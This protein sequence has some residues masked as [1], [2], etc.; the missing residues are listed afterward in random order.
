[1]DLKT[2]IELDTHDVVLAELGVAAIYRPA[3]DQQGAGYATRVIVRGEPERAAKL[4]A[5]RFA[6]NLATHERRRYRVQ[7][8]RVHAGETVSD[9]KAGDRGGIVELSPGDTLEIAASELGAAGAAG[10]HRLKIAGEAYRPSSVAGWW[11]A[12]GTL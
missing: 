6:S 2:A 4:G 1:M 5:G 8:P 7:V 11:I 10:T 12:E 9:S 3:S